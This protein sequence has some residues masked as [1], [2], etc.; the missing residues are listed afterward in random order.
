MEVY[1]Q[2]SLSL[3]LWKCVEHVWPFM[4]QMSNIPQFYFQFN[5]KKPENESED[6]SQQ[7]YTLY[8]LSPN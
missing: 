6:H 2:G 5:N 7:L 3:G 1:S 4:S 8:W